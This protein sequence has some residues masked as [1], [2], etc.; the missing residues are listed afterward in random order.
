M[1]GSK[2]GK[3]SALS[4]AAFTKSGPAVVST[5]ALRPLPLKS[6]DIQKSNSETGMTKLNTANE[7]T[8]DNIDSSNNTNVT[9]TSDGPTL[10]VLKHVSS[11]LSDSVDDSAT[12]KVSVKDR[13]LA[14]LGKTPSSAAS[15]SVQE[16]VPSK[17][18]PIVLKPPRSSTSWDA[19]N[20]KESTE[21]I[22]QARMIP[23]SSEVD[24]SPT[25][26]PT[27]AQ[28]DSEISTKKHDHNYTVAVADTAAMSSEPS[29][30]PAAPLFPVES[31]AQPLQEAEV[32][33][34]PI[35]EHI[36]IPIALAA[37]VI[38][39]S[40][41][42]VPEAEAVT[43]DPPV[44]LVDPPAAALPSSA[45]VEPVAPIPV[46]EPASAPVVIKSDS[47]DDSGTAKM[48]AKERILARMKKNKEAAQSEK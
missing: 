29:V 37:E 19:A 44:L 42:D 32:E 39:S 45:T 27:K 17:E 22:L 4:A 13:L 40:E 25:P 21:T 24:D 9:T 48:S 15:S 38:I 1:A 11:N 18:K 34:K 28:P 10:P 23:P 33:V 36:D 26:L 12:P 3:P 30:E 35:E 6:T 14:R 47:N 5:T 20:S 7:T 43:A 46:A 2:D 8:S 31:I 16:S 41:C